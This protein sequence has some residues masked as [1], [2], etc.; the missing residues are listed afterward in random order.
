[1]KKTILTCSLL[2]TAVFSSHA[3]STGNDTNYYTDYKA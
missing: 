1:M 2:L 3:A